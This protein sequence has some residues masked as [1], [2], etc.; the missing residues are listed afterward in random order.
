[1][2]RAQS[3]ASS[4][5]NHRRCRDAGD[6]I[7][8]AAEERRGK[9]AASRD[10]PLTKTGNLPSLPPRPLRRVALT[11]L[12]FVPGEAL[13]RDGMRIRRREGGGATGG[14][15]V[16]VHESPERL[17]DS[18]DSLRVHQRLHFDECVAAAAVAETWDS[19]GARDARDAT[20]SRSLFYPSRE[21]EGERESKEKKR[22]KR[23]LG[24]EVL[25][26]IDG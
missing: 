16:N 1:M 23:R 12:R 15:E 4:P 9:R 17:V 19:P 21:S 18:I 20:R 11:Q 5:K 7:F 6:S 10:S 14:L 26:E 2:A 3:R 22:I 8:K 25:R 13:F 24:L